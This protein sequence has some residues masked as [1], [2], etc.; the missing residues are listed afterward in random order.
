MTDQVRERALWREML[1]DYVTFAKAKWMGLVFIAAIVALK[2]MIPVLNYDI[3]KLQSLVAAAG[4]SKDVSELNAFV[5]VNGFAMIFTTVFQIAGFIGVSYILTVMGLKVLLPNASQH[6]SIKGFALWLFRMMQ[7]YVLILGPFVVL[8]VGAGALANMKPQENR[9]AIAWIYL[10]LL[11]VWVAYAGHFLL[12]LILVSPLSVLGRDQVF[13][14]ST[15]MTKGNLYRIWSGL[16]SVLA[17]VLIVFIPL[18]LLHSEVTTKGTIQADVLRA[19]SD[20][21]ITSVFLSAWTLYACSVYRALLQEQ[22]D[23]AASIDTH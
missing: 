4:K 7:K 6:L 13:K 12:R 3:D 22:N 2:G 21:I 19:I 1:R 20:G 8:R 15:D 9:S 17:I 23:R 18:A 10:A 16:L 14:T 5:A 11:F